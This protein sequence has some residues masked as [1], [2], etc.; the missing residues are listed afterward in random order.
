MMNEPGV[1]RYSV[2][3]DIFWKQNDDLVFT[4]NNEEILVAT[5]FESKEEGL[6]YV[7]YELKVGL[8]GCLEY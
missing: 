3:S 1:D 5:L 7:S 8:E 6:V 4:L 2:D